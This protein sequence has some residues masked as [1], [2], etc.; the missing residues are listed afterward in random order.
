MVREQFKKAH[1]MN[2]ELVQRIVDQ[3]VVKRERHGTTVDVLQ[4]RKF[5]ELIVRE[6]GAYLMR[7]E[8]I[9]RSDLDWSIVLNEHFGIKE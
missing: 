9:G 3:C 7:P 4:S 6:A 1:T 8:F 2:E 5:A